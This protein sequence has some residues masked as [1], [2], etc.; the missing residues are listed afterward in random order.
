MEHLS[1][2]KDRLL[3]HATVLSMGLDAPLVEL[4]AVVICALFKVDLDDLVSDFGVDKVKLSDE[5]LG[6]LVFPVDVEL[7]KEGLFFLEVAGD[8]VPSIGQAPVSLSVLSLYVLDSLVKLSELLL[9]IIYFTHVLEEHAH[10]LGCLLGD[11]VGAQLM[12][13]GERALHLMYVSFALS[14]PSPMS[15]FLYYPC[16]HVHG[17]LHLSLSEYVLA[18]AV[19]GGV[20]SFEDSAFSEDLEPQPLEFPLFLYFLSHFLLFLFLQH[21][22]MFY[23]SLAYEIPFN[24]LKYVLFT[25]FTLNVFLLLLDELELAG[26]LFIE[27]GLAH[28]LEIAPVLDEGL[29]L[30]DEVEVGHEV[31]ALGS[32]R[33]SLLP[34]LLVLSQR[35]YK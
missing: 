13:Y 18:F 6:A 23:Y 9:E 20:D 34:L 1:P 8:E 3:V 10:F 25:L 29:V 12:A 16:K 27:L 15:E 7:D 17:V 2:R 21:K 31:H 26:S 35:F 14:F 33:A 4:H 5:G 11:Q 28:G 32:R 19:E 30:E 22:I 24:Q